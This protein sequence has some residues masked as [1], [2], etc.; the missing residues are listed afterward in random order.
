MT[1]ILVIDPGAS[2]GYCVIAHDP[3]S[4]SAAI[5]EY[6]TVAPDTA[7][8]YQGDHTI[9]LMNKVEHLIK[10]WSTTELGMENYFASSRFAQGTDI[11][12]YYRGAIQIACRRLGQHYEML[13]ISNWKTHVA[14]R[15]TP[16]KDEK[17]KYGKEAAKKI[18]I[19]EAL[20]TRWNVR[21][22]NHM[23]S[24]TTGKPVIFKHDA[25]DAVGQAI[26]YVWLRFKCSTV[27]NTVPVPP[28][29]VFKKKSKKTFVYP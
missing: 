22:P 26:Y 3:L 13:N 10:T 5:L 28:D 18:M 16:T 27:S 14:G 6:G 9:D 2:S 19:Q 24:P 25:V 29:V 15:S 20:W 21:F 23:I 12:Y 11:N 17:A 1:N 8:S 4:N 7:S